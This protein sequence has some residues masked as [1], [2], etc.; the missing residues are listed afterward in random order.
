MPHQFLPQSNPQPSVTPAATEPMVTVK[1]ADGT[2][3]KVPLS[4]IRKLRNKEMKGADI[5]NR[6]PPATASGRGP[7][8][9][10]KNTKTFKQNE[11]E[12]SVKIVV[13][14]TG[15]QS[16]VRSPKSVV[17][18]PTTL[19]EGIEMILAERKRINQSTVIGETRN[20]EI[21]KL[22]N[23]EMAKLRSEE[24]K[25]TPNSER[26]TPN[27]NWAANDH[28]SLLDDEFHKENLPMVIEARQ[29]ALAKV[30]PMA[31]KHENIK[32]LKQENTEST[33]AISNQSSAI[34]L[35]KADLPAE[36]RAQAV[37]RSP[38]SVVKPM[39]HDIQPPTYVGAKRSLGPVDEIGSFA[40][41][42]LR[43][44]DVT[45]QAAG[46]KLLQ[47]FE[48][49]REESYLLY[50]E[51]VK[52]WRQSPLYRQYQDVLLRALTGRQTVSQ[53]LS[54]SQ[55]REAMKLPEWG[56]VVRVNQSLV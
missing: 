6:P 39:M 28:K 43:H 19:A 50:M 52:A 9:G 20:S 51:G 46:S 42:D 44:L 55:E 35:Q 21:T 56:A 16:E 11:I 24:M 26:R 36:A 15:G 17:P 33:K 34:R 53:V 31:L 12:K 45:P 38:S 25:G 7:A 10:G 22:R 49:L 14:A 54:E 30:R 47:K 13:Q 5:G 1:K 40:L 4:E 48:T 8:Q 32:T 37:V 29:K 3:M 2:M 23:S 27:A 18:Q 41:A